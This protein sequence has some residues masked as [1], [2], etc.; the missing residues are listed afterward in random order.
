MID[1]GCS[2]SSLMVEPKLIAKCLVSDDVNAAFRS[3]LALCGTSKICQYIIN[4]DSFFKDLV[5]LI[6]PNH[7]LFDLRNESQG[8]AAPEAS[9]REKI[10]FRRKYFDLRN[11]FLQKSET[12][13]GTVFGEALVSEDGVEVISFHSGIESFKL[14]ENSTFQSIKIPENMRIPPRQ[15]YRESPFAARSEKFLAINH[16]SDSA[17]YIYTAEGVNCIAKYEVSGE[18]CQ[19]TIEGDLLCVVEQQPDE[20]RNL[21]AFNLGAP[22]QQDPITIALPKNEELW[23]LPHPIC[24]GEKYLIYTQSL[25]QGNQIYALPLSCLKETT[26]GSPLPWIEGAVAAEGSRY[27]LAKGDHFIEV[28]FNERYICDISKVTIAPEG[29]L[30]TKIGNGI[31][32]PNNGKTFPRDVCFH[33]DR[34]F[35]ACENLF[36]G[37]KIFSYDITLGRLAELVSISQTASNCPFRPRFLS[38]AANIYYLIMGLGEQVPGTNTCLMQG[39]LTTLTYGKV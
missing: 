31:K 9:E 22:Q 15:V 2:F 12:F 13:P 1:L 28:T 37:T 38:T 24:F 19:L 3:A 18:I 4:A 23:P 10:S 29:F 32:I 34:L 26:D 7:P 20:S 8:K 5:E 39:Y 17:I 21:V 36:S 25:S 6:D 30:K 14:K 33:R 35:L 11:I 27:M 16:R